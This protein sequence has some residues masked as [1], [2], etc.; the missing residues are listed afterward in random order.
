MCKWTSPVRL[1]AVQLTFEQGT[2]G[3]DQ[4]DAIKEEILKGR[5]WNP[6]CNLDL[7]SIHEN[8]ERV[9]RDAAAATTFYLK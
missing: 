3:H 8:L 6:E 7:F 5:H 9:G 1:I 4:K 2:A